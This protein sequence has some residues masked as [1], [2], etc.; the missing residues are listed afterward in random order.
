ME[1]QIVVFAL[2]EE[3]FGV[4]IFS[5]ER[6]IDIQPIAAVPHSPDFISGVTNLYGEVLPVLDLRKRFGLPIVKPTRDSRIVVVD[7]SDVKVGMLVDAVSEVVSIDDARI[8]SPPDLVLTPIN[9]AYIAGIAKLGEEE[10]VATDEL[11]VSDKRLIIMLNLVE[12]LSADE[13]AD[14]QAF[15]RILEK[16]APTYTASEEMEDVGA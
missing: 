8:E 14:L 1:R 4:D 9:R 13:K 11:G 12:V 2:E 7:V 6:I 5:V 10:L 3:Y 16:D 15:E